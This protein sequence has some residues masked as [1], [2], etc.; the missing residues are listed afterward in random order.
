MDYVV[1]VMPDQPSTPAADTFDT[2]NADIFIFIHTHW[3]VI[4]CLTEGSLSS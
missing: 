2:L 4:F 3:N 1:D